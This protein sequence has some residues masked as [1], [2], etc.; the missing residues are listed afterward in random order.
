MPTL[1]HLCLLLI[2]FSTLVSSERLPSLIEPAVYN[3]CSGDYPLPLPSGAAST[4]FFK[5]QIRVNPLQINNNGTGWEEW[6]FLAH[7]RLADGSELVYSYKWAL[8]DPTSANV[9]R[10]A[11]V[12]WAY[13]PNGTFY[14]QVVHDV[15]EYEERVDGSFTYS[16]ANNHL[17]WDPAR[18]LWNTS[19]SVGGWII[20]SS[21]ANFHIIVI[22]IAPVCALIAFTLPARREYRGI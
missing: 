19:I 9:S 3:N 16:I 21:S 2:A 14:H 12:A 10:H 15:F 8:G 4:P 17:T 20:E 7:N 18:E 13:F 6:L 22:P 11:F 5:P 1:V